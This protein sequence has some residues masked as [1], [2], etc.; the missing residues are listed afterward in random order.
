MVTARGEA[1]VPVQRDHDCVE[2]ASHLDTSIAGG[3][4]DDNDGDPVRVGQ[5]ANAVWKR[6]LAVVRDDDD[7]DFTLADGPMMEEPKPRNRLDAPTEALCFQLVDP[8][9][10]QSYFERLHVFPASP[11]IGAGRTANVRP[12]DELWSPRVRFEFETFSA[13]DPELQIPFELEQQ[14]F[15]VVRVE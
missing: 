6:G 3:V 10:A 4:V 14:A 9:P 12:C 13:R 11:P 5:R 2:V 8:V 15:E 7:I 1:E